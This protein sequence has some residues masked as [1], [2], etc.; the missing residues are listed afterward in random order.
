[1]PRAADSRQPMRTRRTSK[2]RRAALPLVTLCVVGVLVGLF[3]RPA[4]GQEPPA[5][6]SISPAQL[7][8]AIDKLGDL[9]YATRTTASRTVRRTAGPQACPPVACRCRACR[10]L[11]AVSRAGPAD[12]LQRSA[13]RRCDARVADES[14]RPPP[15]G[16]IPFL[17][18]Q[19]RCP[20]GAHSTG[21]NGEGA[22]GVRPPGIGARARGPRCGR[23][24]ATPALAGGR[25]R[26]GFLPQRGDR[27]LGDYKAQY[28]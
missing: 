14:Q 27:A 17:R 26:R 4:R 18:A 19:S 9:D 15:H 3:E 1:M 20:H 5:P 22:G 21:R 6:Q 10:R 7:Q 2:V 8:A 16:R 24:C 25:A 13:D 12:R 11:C 28:A 23:A